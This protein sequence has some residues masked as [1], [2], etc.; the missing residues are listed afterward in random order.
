MV[1]M[2]NSMDFWFHQ[3]TLISQKWI[4]LSLCYLLFR[5]RTEKIWGR[6][7][8]N[9]KSTDTWKLKPSDDKWVVMNYNLNAS[10]GRAACNYNLHA[11]SM[12]VSSH[13]DSRERST[14]RIAS[15]VTHSLIFTKQVNLQWGIVPYLR[16]WCS[17]IDPHA[18]LHKRA[19]CQLLSRSSPTYYRDCHFREESLEKV[20]VLISTRPTTGSTS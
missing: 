15:L 8:L 1:S 3:L 10:A 2:H 16:A 18:L 20:T 6:E 14:D 5:C 7:T 13:Q 4:S 17:E 19:P 11:G 9:L 12:Q